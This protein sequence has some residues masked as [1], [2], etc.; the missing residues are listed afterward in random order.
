VRP[1]PD[2]MATIS[3]LLK[4]QTAQAI[5]AKVNAACAK[6]AKGDA[7]T[8]DQ[9]RVDTLAEMILTGGGQGAVPAAMVHLVVNVESLIGLDETP[10]QLE[11]YGSITPGQ[12][13]NLVLAPGSK[14]R[15]LFVTPTGKLVS[16][17]PH[18]Y[19]LP[20]W[21]DRYLRLLNRTCTFPGLKCPRGAAIWT[22]CT[23]SATGGAVARRTCTPRAASTTNKRPPGSGVPRNTAMAPCGFP[24]PLGDR[25]SA[26]RSRIR[27]HGTRGR[28]SNSGGGLGWEA[29]SCIWGAF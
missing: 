2:G 11:G 13:R 28:G 3:I 27:R 4:A 24:R 18:Q 12:A 21:L 7:R 14:L 10:A 23:R 16:V 5:A 20:T 8:L 6:R 15:R 9:R 22:T 29:G 26:P 17:D 1:E 25:M 19:R